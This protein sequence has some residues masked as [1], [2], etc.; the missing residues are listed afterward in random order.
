MTVSQPDIASENVS[1]SYPTAPYFHSGVGR[2][3]FDSWLRGTDPGQNVSLYIHILRM[4]DQTR[5]AL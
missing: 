5:P 2:S 3:Q 4:H 1:T